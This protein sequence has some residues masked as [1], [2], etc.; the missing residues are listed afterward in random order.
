MYTGTNKEVMD[1][2]YGEE[3]IDADSEAVNFLK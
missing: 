3:D 1:D 2:S